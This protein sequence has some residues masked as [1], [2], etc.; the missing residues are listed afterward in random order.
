LQVLVRCREPHEPLGSGR[1]RQWPLADACGRGRSLR[2]GGVARVP[3]WFGLR[4]TRTRRTKETSSRP[5]PTSA[6]PQIRTP[7]MYCS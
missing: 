6:G 7:D 5:R 1:L 3:W 2:W 4:R